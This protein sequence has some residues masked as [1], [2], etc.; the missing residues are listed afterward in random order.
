MTSNHVHLL[1]YDQK[2]KY[3]I[4]KSMQLLAGRIGQEYNIRKKRKGAFWQ[5]RY[6]ATA[7]E[8]GEHLRQCI[9][10]I[11]LNMVR[12]GMTNHP[13]KWYW[14]GY[15]EIQKPRRK[16][17][18]INYEILSELTGFDNFYDFQAAHKNWVYDAVAKCN[19]KREG[20]WTESIAIGSNDFVSEMH[21]RL[22]VQIKGRKIVE[23]GKA[24]QIR[25][26]IKP[27]NAIFDAEKRV[28]AH[29]NTFNWNES[30]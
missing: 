15:N 28:I 17:T 22:G 10:Y 27:Y 29:E 2:G 6:H 30:I 16:N 21:Y 20:H 26:D 9:V 5:D 4:P 7:I 11:D 12:T 19:L 13:S 18:L 1:V 3:I 23:V 8:T 25:E 14:S 24:F